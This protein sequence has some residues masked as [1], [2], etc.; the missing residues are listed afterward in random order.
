MKYLRVFEG[1]PVEIEA[2]LE[3]DVGSHTA[4]RS[5]SHLGCQANLG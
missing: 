4:R 1:F 5:V 3:R 2:E